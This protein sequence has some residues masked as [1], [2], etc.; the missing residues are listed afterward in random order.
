LGWPELVF[1]VGMVICIGGT[2]FWIK[3]LIECATKEADTGNTK[4]A[5]IIVI[6]VA[7]VIGAAIYY[8]VR[9]PQ[10]YADLHR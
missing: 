2:V 9:R 10:R 3:M 8:F 5:W 7:H 6:A 4:V 1:V